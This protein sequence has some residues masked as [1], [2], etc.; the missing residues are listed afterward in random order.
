[1]Q[2]QMPVYPVWNHSV[3]MGHISAVSLKQAKARARAKWP[4]RRLQIDAPINKALSDA[5]RLESNKGMQ[6]KAVIR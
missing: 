3:F 5:D 2:N 6:A 1:M 4:H